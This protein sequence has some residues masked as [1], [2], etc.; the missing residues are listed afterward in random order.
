MTVSWQSILNRN[1]E[2]CWSIDL[3]EWTSYSTHTGTGAQIDAVL[4]LAVIDA[5]DGVPGNLTKVFTR[6]WVSLPEWL[7]SVCIF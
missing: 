3:Q 1:Y 2:V 4:D 7:L 5:A 6:I